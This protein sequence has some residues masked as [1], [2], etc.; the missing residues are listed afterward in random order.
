MTYFLADTENIA[1]R[2]Y[3]SALDAEPGDIFLLFYSDSSKRRQDFDIFARASL[4]G[5]NFRFVK[6]YNKRENALD[7]QLT[8]YLGVLFASHPD[9]KFVILSRDEGF[10]PAVL[11]L[12]DLGADVW[13]FAPPVRAVIPVPT[14]ARTYSEAVLPVGPEPAAPSGGSLPDDAPA[15][16]P[17][18]KSEV[19][20]FIDSLPACDQGVA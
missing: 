20:R 2:W 17:A 7:F 15:V 6:C 3:G 4:R 9:D 10:D 19:R 1:D 11:F 12:R 5:V 18:P 8:A 16:R 14:L 13:R